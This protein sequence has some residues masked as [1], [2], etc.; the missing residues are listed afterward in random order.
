M[1]LFW[2]ESTF[3]MISNLSVLLLQISCREWG[4]LNRLKTVFTDG[5]VETLVSPMSQL[6]IYSHYCNI[7]TQINVPE[8]KKIS[9][10][11]YLTSKSLWQECIATHCFFITVLLHF[12]Y[13]GLTCLVFLL[14]LY[15]R[16]AP[17]AHCLSLSTYDGQ[18]TCF[19]F[20]FPFLAP[21]SLADPPSRQR[22]RTRRKMANFLTAILGPNE[23]VE[24]TNNWIADLNSKFRPLQQ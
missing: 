15:C 16:K 5:W 3:A 4:S 10:Y 6:I 8:L 12:L 21:F 23:T 2:L 17:A 24:K 20:F 1:F 19:P 13:T 18:Y 9:C 14:Y 7:I 22:E 11:F